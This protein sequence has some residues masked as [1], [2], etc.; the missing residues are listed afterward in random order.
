MQDGTDKPDSI[1]HIDEI[2]RKTDITVYSVECNWEDAIVRWFKKLF[3]GSKDE[4]KR[5]T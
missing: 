4:T 1:R 2:T 3:G 5:D